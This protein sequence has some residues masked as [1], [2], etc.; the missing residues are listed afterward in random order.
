MTEKKVFVFL[1]SFIC[2]YEL[3]KLVKRSWSVNLSKKMQTSC[4]QVEVLSQLF[5][6]SQVLVRSWST[7]TPH[8]GFSDTNRINNNRNNNNNN[9]LFNLRHKIYIYKSQ[10]LFLII[11]FNAY[12]LL[13]SRNWT[14]NNLEV[15]ASKSLS[16][17]S[18]KLYSRRYTSLT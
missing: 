15:T 9:R 11:S 2:E 18:E 17:T 14:K 13:G 4:V 5:F 8:I 3:W 12:I 16:K 6:D 1:Y 7:W 10:I